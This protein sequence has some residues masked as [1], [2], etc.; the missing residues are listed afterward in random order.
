MKEIKWNKS[1]DLVVN[2]HEGKQDAYYIITVVYN[3]NKEYEIETK[4]KGYYLMVCNVPQFNVETNELGKPDTY[5]A[6]LRLLIQCD[7]RSEKNYNKAV[8]MMMDIAKDSIEIM[9]EDKKYF[10]TLARESDNMTP[11]QIREGLIKLQHDLENM[12]M[13]ELSKTEDK[14]VKSKKEVKKENKNKKKITFADVAG[15][16]E[17]K[18]T[19]KDVID[20]LKRPEL[21]KHFD[22]EPIKSLLMYGASGTGKTFIAN[23][24]ANEID[25]N[26]VK[27]SMGDIA[28]KY[29]GQTGNNIKRIFDEARK[30][31]KF[32]VLFWDEVDAVANRRGMDENSKEKNST[33]NVLLTEMSSDDNDNIFMI[34]ATNYIELIDDAFLRSGRCDI[35]IKVPLP[36]VETRLQI[37]ELNTRKKPLGEDVEL[38][39]IAKM[40]EGNNCADVSLLVNQSARVALKKDKMEI[41]QEDFLET[42]ENLNMKKKE[43][44]SKKI[45]FSL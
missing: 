25:A 17:V 18:N 16:E 20:Q 7:R 5:Y 43:E 32:T 9:E 11:Q 13:E 14:I 31:D 44:K 10:E 27:V 30:S 35:K 23:A 26:F 19:F 45:G 6:D 15:M 28:S 1:D 21:Y 3:D 38:R 29:Q 8:D 33:M 24:F 12:D 40:M 36:D 22:I 39:T 4:I 41:N 34:F 2:F 42:L 37:L